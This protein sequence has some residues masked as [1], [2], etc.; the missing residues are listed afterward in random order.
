M[1]ATDRADSLRSSSLRSAAAK[2]DLMKG[3]RT[4]VGIV[5]GAA[6]GLLFGQMSFDS[7]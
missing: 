2:G 6:I 4:G 1:T 7:W 3:L 5:F